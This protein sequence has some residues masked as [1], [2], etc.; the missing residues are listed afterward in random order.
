[1]LNGK[2]QLNNQLKKIEDYKRGEG[3]IHKRLAFVKPINK[4]VVYLDGNHM[5]WNN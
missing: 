3:V 4:I 1:M 2:A 5:T